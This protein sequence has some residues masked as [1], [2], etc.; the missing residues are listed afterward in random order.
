ME[1]LLLCIFQCVTAVIQEM[2]VILYYTYLDVRYYPAVLNLQTA[3]LMKI[4]VI[5][6]YLFLNKM[7]IK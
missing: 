7:F 5:V 4:H 6:V 1:I 3:L 2:N